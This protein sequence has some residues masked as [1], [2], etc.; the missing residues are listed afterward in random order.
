[1]FGEKRT[2]V[3]TVKKTVL[4]L[5]TLVMAFSFAV[6]SVYATPEK[7]KQTGKDCSECHKG[8]KKGPHGK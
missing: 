8:N 1:M 7:A 3:S 6:S 2:E 4:A 5:V